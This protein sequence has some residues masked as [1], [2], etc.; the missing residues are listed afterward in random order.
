MD[1]TIVVISE[2]ISSIVMIG[3]VATLFVESRQLRTSRVRASRA[4]HVEII[5]LVLDYPDIASVVAL[6]ISSDDYKKYAF[7]GLLLES[8]ELDYELR[9][10]SAKSIKVQARTIFKSDYARTWWSSVARQAWRDAAAAKSEKEFF[11]LVD[12][13]FDESA[14]GG[15]TGDPGGKA[16]S[17]RAD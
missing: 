7:F 11:A 3:V 16:D 1:T 6:D 13:E 17:P 15:R 12:G 4:L 10:M 14:P 2:F 9:T 5:R 8:W